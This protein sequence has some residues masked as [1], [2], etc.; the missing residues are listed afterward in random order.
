ME[1]KVKTAS[2]LRKEINR[3]KKLV[4]RALANEKPKEVE[5]FEKEISILQEDL[6][7][8][9]KA[10]KIESDKNRKKREEENSTEEKARLAKKE[11]FR[12]RAENEIHTLDLMKETVNVFP[13]KG[14]I[15]E[16]PCAKIL[17][18]L[19]KLLK[20]VDT[21][22]HEGLTVEKETDGA[23]TMSYSFYSRDNGSCEI[24]VG[25][26]T[27]PQAFVLSVK[28]VSNSYQPEIEPWTT[29]NEDS[30][31]YCGSSIIRDIFMKLGSLFFGEIR[32]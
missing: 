31:F 5:G 3:L 24:V 20:S 29:I 12:K 27:S 14:G 17:P 21:F 4:L 1:A 18:K 19:Q 22:S 32:N 30:F 9:E 7:K 26:I 11:S 15:I 28:V 16:I 25:D 2:D 6:K 8:L 13:E 10:E 23:I